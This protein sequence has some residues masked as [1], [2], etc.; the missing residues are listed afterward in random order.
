M[1]DS[2]LTQNFNRYI[3][4]TELY[5]ISFIYKTHNLILSAFNFL[6]VIALTSHLPHLLSNLRPSVAGC[7]LDVVELADGKISHHSSQ[8][9]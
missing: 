6:M 8:Q 4:F 7:S 3:N 9:Q 1:V 2:D 5:I